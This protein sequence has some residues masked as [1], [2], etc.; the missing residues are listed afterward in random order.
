MSTLLTKKATHIGHG[1]IEAAEATAEAFWIEVVPL[2][3]GPDDTAY[4]PATAVA[5][6]VK[7]GSFSRL[8][9]ICWPF[10]GVSSRMGTC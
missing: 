7:V 10:K 4:S 8:I 9:V 3:A 6:E 2:E 1:N 5:T